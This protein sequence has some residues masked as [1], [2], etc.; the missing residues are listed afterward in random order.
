MIDSEAFQVNIFNVLNFSD[1]KYNLFLVST[2]KEAAYPLM[3]KNEKII[4]FDNKN[5]VA[6]VETYIRTSYLIY[7]LC[8][9]CYQA[10]SFS[11]SLSQNRASWIE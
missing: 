9:E 11:C 4:V 2:I 5:N 1:F 3:P 6:L 8:H 10:L 7:V